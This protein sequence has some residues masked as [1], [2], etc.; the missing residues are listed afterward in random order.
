MDIISALRSVCFW[1]GGAAPVA[2]KVIE[3]I[4]TH[5]VEHGGAEWIAK[6]YYT[7]KYPKWFRAGGKYS[8]ALVPKL[9]GYFKIGAK[10]LS[11][12]GWVVFDLEIYEC[13][14]KCMK[15]L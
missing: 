15:C 2:T 10:I 13:T 1:R 7:L 14:K 9:A 4:V 6:K 3:K 8:E 5:G 12:A 11:V